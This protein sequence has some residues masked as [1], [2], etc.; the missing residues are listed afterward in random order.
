MHPVPR[1][2]SPPE[3]LDSFVQKAHA[4]QRVRS[5]GGHLLVDQ[6]LGPHLLNCEEAQDPHH[7]R[8]VQNW[9][10]QGSLIFTLNKLICLHS[11]LLPIAYYSP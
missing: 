6:K 8:T 3:P 2:V 7:N 9:F 10:S 11:T 5:E 1:H 4:V